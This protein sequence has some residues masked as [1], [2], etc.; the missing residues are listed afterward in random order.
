MSERTLPVSDAVATDYGTTSVVRWALTG[1]S[2]AMLMPS[3][4]TSIANASLPAMAR[5]FNAP[6][7]EVQWIVLAYLLA[8]TTLIVGAGRLG[9]IVGRRRLLLS[10]IA[11]FSGA[12]LLCGAA[13]TLWMLVAARTAQGLGAAI[14]MAL[15]IAFVGDTVPKAKTGSAM[16]LLGTMSAVGTTLGPPLGGL[17]IARVGWKA[18]FLVNVPFGILAFLVARRYLPP[19]RQERNQTLTTFDTAGTLLLVLTLAAYALAMTMGQGGF[20]QLNIALMVASLGAAGLFVLVEARTASP[21]IRLAALREP[22]LSGGLV[23]SALVSTVMMATLVVGPFYLSLALGLEAAMVG[24]VLSVG[25]LVSALTGVPAGRGVDRIGADRMAIAGLAGLGI[26]A[27][28]L[29]VTAGRFGI[30]GYL[31]PIVSMTAGYA[32]FQAANNTLMMRGASA[33]QRGVVAGMLSL[34]RNLGLI[35]GSAFMGA[36]FAFGSGAADIT[37][38]RPEAVAVGMR[39]AFAAAA[40]LILFALSIAI[41]ARR[42]HQHRSIVMKKSVSVVITGLTLALSIASPAVAQ[43]AG[44][45]PTVSS[46]TGAYVTVFRSPGTGLEYR[47]GRI[48]IHA[49]HYVTV[50]KT[51]DQAT[52]KSTNFVRAGASFYLRPAGWTPFLSPSVVLSLDDDWDNGVLTEVGVRIPV[53]SRA[54]FRGGVGVLRTFDGE[55]RV[56]PT[57]GLDV[58]MGRR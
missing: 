58:R 27:A 4:D 23:M 3:L 35:T 33:D 39:I 49:A 45:A 43:D 24:L 25:P 36:V 5:A 30:A 16:G 7:R 32:V 57:I 47:F 2:L 37:T 12:S 51:G 41:A 29:A 14:M 52:G 21:L 13:T 9:D 46:E 19:D 20:N 54:S 31:V 1:L 10:G 17:L 56:N 55:T 6:F 22:L 26:G 44:Q 48:A 11:L 38:A 53:F 28:G 42:A 40:L 18:I 34:A 15:A 50:L 8:I